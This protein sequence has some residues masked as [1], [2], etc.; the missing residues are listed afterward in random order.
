[1]PGTARR[2]RPGRVGAAIGR[3]LGG[4]AGGGIGAGVSGTF[5]L[6]GRVLEGTARGLPPPRRKR[7]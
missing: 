1:M 2:R 3:R 7:R 6:A 5:R 4:A